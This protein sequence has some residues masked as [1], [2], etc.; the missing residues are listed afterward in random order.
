MKK[1]KSLGK[2]SI[3]YQFMFKY[4][5]FEQI[6]LFKFFSWFINVNYSNTVLIHIS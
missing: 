6:M 5:K 4:K 1:I 2:N 3:R